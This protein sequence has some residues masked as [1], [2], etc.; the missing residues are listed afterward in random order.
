MTINKEYE[1]QYFE[2]VNVVFR[3]LRP[4]DS[5]QNIQKNQWRSVTTEGNNSPKI[6]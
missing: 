1:I 4:L 6:F 5:L 3:Y 2:H